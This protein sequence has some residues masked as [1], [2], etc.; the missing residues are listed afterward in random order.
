MYRSPICKRITGLLKVTWSDILTYL[1]TAERSATLKRQLHYASKKLSLDVTAVFPGSGET[2]HNKFSFYF[3]VFKNILFLSSVLCTVNHYRLL[4][5]SRCL[6]IVNAHDEFGYIIYRPNYHE[7]S[8]GYAAT[9]P[10]GC[11]SCEKSFEI[12]CYLI[13]GNWSH[14]LWATGIPL[15][16]LDIAEFCSSRYIILVG[17]NV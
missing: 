2:T 8:N 16:F 6:E 5:K 10:T 4:K 13:G 1:K 3:N 11:W 17:T 9:S 12:C 7:Q 14:D 15:I